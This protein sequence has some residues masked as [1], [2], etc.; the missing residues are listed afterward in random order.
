MSLFPSALKSATA[1]SLAFVTM[2]LSGSPAAAPVQVAD[3]RAVLGRA[4]TLVTRR[5]PSAGGSGAL[6]RGVQC[7]A[8]SAPRTDATQSGRLGRYLERAGGA[9]AI[10]H[11][12]AVAVMSLD[13]AG[14]TL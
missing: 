2:V 9:I 11:R 5:P 1:T 6:P 13:A 14:A 12:G 4:P 8:A 7:A 3:A 10:C